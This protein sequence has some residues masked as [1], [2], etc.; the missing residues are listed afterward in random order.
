MKRTIEQINHDYIIRIERDRLLSMI[1][2]T[3]SKAKSKFV[4]FKAESLNGSVLELQLNHNTRLAAIDISIVQPFLKR[5]T[6][7]GIQ[8]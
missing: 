2:R 5:V 4:E 1:H 8:L 3:K 7:N 6:K